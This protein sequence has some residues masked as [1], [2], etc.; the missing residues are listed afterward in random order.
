MSWAKILLPPPPSIFSNGF[1]PHPADVRITRVELLDEE[2]E[3]V[4]HIYG[5]EKCTSGCAIWFD[6]EMEINLSDIAYGHIDFITSAV[7]GNL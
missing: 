7:N 3:E 5:V 4:L 2:D 6:D 1:I